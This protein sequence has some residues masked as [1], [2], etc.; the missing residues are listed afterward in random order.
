MGR[1]YAGSPEV[2]AHHRPGAIDR[3]GQPIA[4]KPTLGY[5]REMS[6]PHISTLRIAVLRATGDLRWHRLVRDALDTAGSVTA[7]ARLLGIG[8]GTLQRWITET[9]ELVVGIDLPT[10]PG[11]PAFTKTTKTH[12]GAIE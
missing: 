4:L 7:A 8:K 5:P 12:K 6:A 3:A 11:N 1:N 10:G 2:R 9:P